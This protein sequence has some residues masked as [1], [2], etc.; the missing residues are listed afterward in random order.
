MQVQER[1]EFGRPS[2]LVHVNVYF[3]SLIEKQILEEKNDN[4]DLGFLLVSLSI[5]TDKQMLF[6]KEVVTVWKT[7]YIP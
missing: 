2:D 1:E 3:K 6:V 7:N 5:I 4:Y